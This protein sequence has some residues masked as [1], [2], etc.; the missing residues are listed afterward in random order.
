MN[1]KPLVRFAAAALA[2]ISLVS[3]SSAGKPNGQ[4][5]GQ[6]A[7]QNPSAQGMPGQ[8][9]GYTKAEVV[10]LALTGFDTLQQVLDATYEGQGFG[11]TVVAAKAKFQENAKDA[12]PETNPNGQPKRYSERELWVMQQV[13]DVTVR[14]VGDGISIMVEGKKRGVSAEVIDA[15]LREM[16]AQNKIKIQQ[17]VADN[18]H[19][20]SS[21]TAGFAGG[22]VDRIGPNG[23]NIPGNVPPWLD[24]NKSPLVV[25]ALQSTQCVMP[26]A[27]WPLRDF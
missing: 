21:E 3:T 16:R 9:R 11:K 17:I 25:L 5:Q 7:G 4:G 23:H 18:A 10:P 27:E 24:P 12:L 13:V 6:H 8:G 2:V 15:N 20:L 26:P 22:V 1:I 14:T 19:E